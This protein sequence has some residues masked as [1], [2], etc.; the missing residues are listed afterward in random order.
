MDR[1]W[2][3]QLHSLFISPCE[4]SLARAH[5]LHY[6]RAKS[7]LST[8]VLCVCMHACV[9]A[10]VCPYAKEIIVKFSL[11]FG[12]VSSPKTVFP[13]NEREREKL[14]V[15]TRK[16]FHTAC[17]TIIYLFIFLCWQLAKHAPRCRHTKR[18]WEKKREPQRKNHFKKK[19]IHLFKR[20]RMK[21]AKVAVQTAAVAA[22][23]NPKP[24][25][26]SAWTPFLVC[27]QIRFFFSFL[28][29]VPSSEN[30][31]GNSGE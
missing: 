13:V 9:C 14:V 19:K 2:G 21:G 31:G 20:H 23:S 8:Q 25:A 28:S 30:K 27:K 12:H 5:A 18:S 15:T 4:I 3:G 16:L 17:W 26:I 6:L 24:P 29:C 7:H 10:R 11:R 22:D 1:Q